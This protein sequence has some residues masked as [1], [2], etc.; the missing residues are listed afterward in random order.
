MPFFTVGHSNRTREA[1]LGL[2]REARIDRLVD[3]RSLPRS[4]RHPHFEAE[5]L[6]ETLTR[7]GIGYFP[8]RSLGGFRRPA[9][10]S[11]NL[12]LQSPGFRGFA[13]FMATSEFEQH[14]SFLLELATKNRLVIMC[15][16]AVYW[17][18]HRFLIADALVQRGEAVR[19]ILEEGRTEEHRLT[20][21]AVVEEGRLVYLPVQ[22][23][24]FPV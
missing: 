14:L 10:D 24:L 21:F 23:G 17:A 4:R 12:G 20:P 2:L 15:A 3:V 9:E 13:D 1:F 19:H 7:E 8:M 5:A 22:K 18:C 16:E 6:R 11:R